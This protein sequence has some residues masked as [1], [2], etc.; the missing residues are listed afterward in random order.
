MLLHGSD[1]NFTNLIDRGCFHQIPDRDLPAYA[2]NVASASSSGARLL[3]FVKAFREGQTGEAERERHRRRVENIL[4]PHFT[5]ERIADT[6]LD[7]DE[8]RIPE[9]RLPGLVLCLVRSAG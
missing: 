9:T 5:I 7:P 8:G 1:R 2:R 6:F 4:G 3:L